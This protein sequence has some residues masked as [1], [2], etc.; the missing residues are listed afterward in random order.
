VYRVRGWRQLQSSLIS[1][2]NRANGR[3]HAPTDLTVGKE[4]WYTLTKRI[5]EFQKLLGLYAKEKEMSLSFRV[6][7]IKAM[8]IIANSNTRHLFDIAVIIK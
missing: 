3:L 4:P 6:S 8:T 2:Q 7:N 5:D 1:V